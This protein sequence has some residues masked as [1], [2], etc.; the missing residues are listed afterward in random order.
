M[1]AEPTPIS[2]LN[3]YVDLIRIGQGEMPLTD[4]LVAARARV[5]QFFADLQE[6]EKLH[7]SSHKVANALTKELRRKIKA[8]S[9]KWE[10][11]EAINVFLEALRQL[12]KQKE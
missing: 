8:A 12:N 4:R 7:P 2:P 9:T 11:A 5:D 6:Y 3:V 10:G 1:T